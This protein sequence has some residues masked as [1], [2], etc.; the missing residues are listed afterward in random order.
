MKFPWR[1]GTDQRDCYSVGGRVIPCSGTGQDA[2]D[3][4]PGPDPANRFE[5]QD[6]TV[7]DRSS[8]LCWCRDAN[9]FDFPFAWE[10]AADLV[11]EMNRSAAEGRRDWRLPSRRELFGLL[12]HQRV[13][14][15]LGQG[16]PFLNVF[17][18]YYWTA[19][20]CARL[21]A[22]A[23]YIHLGGAR[24]YRGMKSGACL[25]WPVAGARRVTGVGDPRFRINDGILQD[26]WTGLCWTPTTRDGCATVSWEGA[27]QAA[28]AV[29]A[30]A[31]GGRRRWRLPNI[32]EL[33]S[34]VDLTRHSPALPAGHGFEDVPDGC[35]SSTTSVY[36]PRYAWVLYLQDGA[37]G[38]G[39]KPQPS[40]CAWAVSDQGRPRTA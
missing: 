14:P 34:L 32:R 1:L 6:A 33:E 2:E 16:H 30:A 29:N 25:V 35:W 40:F 9:R 4:P 11:G 24:V 36:E 10:A 38:V 17:P 18:G 7:I 12:S 20:T 23:W 31:R 8:G 26:L 21:P 28:A 19:T 13:N 22:E 27:L 37:V 3:K 39:F 15:A 5:I